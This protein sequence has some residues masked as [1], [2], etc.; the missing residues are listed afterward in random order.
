MAVTEVTDIKNPD[1]MERLGSSFKG[2]LFGLLLFVLGFPLLF[3]NEGRAVKTARRLSEGAGAVASVPADAIEPANEGR[4]VHVSGMASVD[5]AIADDAF[6]VS[7]RAIRLD[8]QVEIFQ[9][10]EHAET[11]VEREG[12]AEKKITTYTY[13]REWCDAP[14]DSSRFKE[15]GHENST[16][17]AFGHAQWLAP[18]VK[19]GAFSLSPSNIRRIG[20]ARP[21]ALPQDYALPGALVDAGA[22]VVGNAVLV[23]VAPPPQAAPSTN[24]APA[25]GAAPRSVAATP[26]IGDLRVTFRVIDPHE[27]SLVGKQAGNR[28]EPWTGKDGKSLSLQCDG[29]A[30]AATMFAA[31]QSAGKNVA[32]L[33]RLAGFL[34][35][36]VGLRMVFRPLAVLVDVIPVVRALVSGGVALAAF[37]LALACALVTISIAWI[38][39]RPLLAIP[40]LVV[41]VALVVFAF[42]RKRA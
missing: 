29:I 9:W 32:W 31:A 30:D 23:P 27:I 11:R 40:L 18:A 13:S 33:L 19:L 24:G 10:V 3:W 7:A 28:F 37:V 8:R 17:P 16:T 6:G 34:L 14:V 41:A 38:A 2:I 42:R 26:E 15:E 5:G 20:G 36:F 4:L 39:Y 12:D 25:A 35:M 21:F 22:Q 1:W